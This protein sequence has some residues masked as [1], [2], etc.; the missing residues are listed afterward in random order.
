MVQIPWPHTNAPG[1]E[2]QEGAGTLTNVFV[3]RRGDEQSI[4]WRRSPGTKV[5]VVDPSAGSAAGTS[6]V[7]GVSSVVNAIGAAAGT[8]TATGAGSV[9]N[10][11]SGVGQ[12]QGSATATA[13]R[14]VKIA[15]DGSAD[16]ASSATGSS[17]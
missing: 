17:N 15:A 1:D 9:L 10:L 11:L 16:G 5:F 6:V 4:L 3:E 12:A 7:L 8:A 13:E 14:A 2:S